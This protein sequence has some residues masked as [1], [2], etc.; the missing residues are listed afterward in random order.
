[1][2]AEVLDLGRP[3]ARRRRWPGPVAL[4]LGLAAL[5]AGLALRPAPVLDADQ[6]QQVLATG[7]G[8]APV[9]NV[10]EDGDD[11]RPADPGRYTPAGCGI[12]LSP[13][14]APGTA[15]PP[16]RWVHGVFDRADDD[17]R[18]ALVSYLY[19]DADAAR[20]TLAEL[21]RA[22][23]SC[24]EVVYATAG[25]EPA[26]YAVEVA[27]APHG[28]VWFALRG[29]GRRQSV[30]VRRSANAVV[31]QIGYPVLSPPARSEAD[32]FAA[33]LDRAARRGPAG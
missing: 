14:F 7:L 20:T 19:A 32:R 17:R 12:L 22:A 8:R 27:D 9:A 5:A 15:G 10:V 3:P 33:A 16:D 2:P 11:D 4:V 26:R 30:H 25:G 1:M 29:P 6:V 13:V 28:Q 21:D 18:H 24:P 31:L 23:A